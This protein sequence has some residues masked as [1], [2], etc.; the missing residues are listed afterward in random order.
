MTYK[1]LSN[2]TA[3][4]VRGVLAH[5]LKTLGAT[6]GLELTVSPGAVSIGA[7]GAFF[8]DDKWRVSDGGRFVVARAT[9]VAG[10]VEAFIA[11]RQN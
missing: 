3:R 1:Q 4:I 11:L 8:A 7:V 10:V 6:G 9:N 5:E 2:L